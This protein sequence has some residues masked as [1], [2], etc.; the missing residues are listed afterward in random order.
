MRFVGLLAVF[1]ISLCFISCSNEK[2]GGNI[3]LPESYGEKIVEDTSTRSDNDIIYEDQFQNNSAE[4]DEKKKVEDKSKKNNSTKKDNR[5]ES[6]ES[7]SVD[8]IKSNDADV[9]IKDLD[10][11]KVSYEKESLK[12]LEFLSIEYSTDYLVVQ[13]LDVVL[14]VVFNSAKYTDYTNIEIKISCFDE[15]KVLIKSFEEE[16][17]K[18]L[19]RGHK[20]KFKVRFDS[21]ENT[22]TIG[23]NVLSAD[24][25][26]GN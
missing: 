17:S 6:T 14:G 26:L 12:P 8:K 22:K 21:P 16:I 23:V 19:L 4:H 15:D 13:E 10:V 18:N 9:T 7:V 25:V 20:Q 11:K 5:T 1:I 24:P 2:G 3:E